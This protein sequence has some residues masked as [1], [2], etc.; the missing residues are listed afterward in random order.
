[1]QMSSKFKL[2]A[3]QKEEETNLEKVTN[4]IPEVC[5]SSMAPALPWVIVFYLAPMSLS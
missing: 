3:S 2:E 5:E 4:G 1:M